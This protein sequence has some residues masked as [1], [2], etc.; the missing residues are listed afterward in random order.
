MRN[1]LY[2]LANGTIVATY[3]E[4]L[5]SGQSFTV[6]LKNVDRPK[7]DLSPKRKAMLVKL[8][9]LKVKRA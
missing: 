8:P 2:R 6:V 1:L 7:V 4:A 5:E 3:N 9:A